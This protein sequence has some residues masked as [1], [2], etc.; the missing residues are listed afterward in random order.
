MERPVE[1]GAFPSGGV[2]D[3][4]IAQYK[5]YEIIIEDNRNFIMKHKTDESKQIQI[6]MRPNGS[7]GF[8]WVGLPEALKR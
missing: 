8:E 5:D 4:G 2:V 1:P 7:G 6:T 3:G